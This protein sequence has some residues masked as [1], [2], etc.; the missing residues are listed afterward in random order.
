MPLIACPEC[1][2]PV[3]DQAEVCPKCGHPVARE[4]QHLQAR[5]MV[6][7]EATERSR[8]QTILAA[9]VALLGAA[10]AVFGFLRDSIG[11]PELAI[12]V[13]G[14]GLLAVGVL[15]FLHAQF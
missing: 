2:T 3:S 6:V 9:F 1:T 14:A 12:G 10:M 8:L 5:R 15:W 4:Q 11:S 13:A 7:Q